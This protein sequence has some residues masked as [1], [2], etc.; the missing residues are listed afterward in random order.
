M[1][2]DLL[3]SIMLMFLYGPYVYY[4]AF[5][6]RLKYFGHLKPIMWPLIFLWD[7]GLL[8]VIIPTLGV[9]IIFIITINILK[10]LT[11]DLHIPIRDTSKKHNWHH[12]KL[13]SKV[14]KVLLLEKQV[15][16]K[17]T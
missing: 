10:H 16:V 15:T 7:A 17:H 3:R 12:A 13:L 4:F 8:N 14:S 5:I 1:H 2:C 9:V 11:S 6:F